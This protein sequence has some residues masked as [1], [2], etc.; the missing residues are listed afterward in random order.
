M[1]ICVCIDVCVCVCVSVCA[2]ADLVNAPCMFTGQ[3]VHADYDIGHWNRYGAR[4][5]L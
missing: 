2:C 1:Y 4:V 5:L 3:V